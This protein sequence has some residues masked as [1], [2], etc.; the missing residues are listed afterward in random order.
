VREL[1]RRPNL[2]IKLSDLPVEADFESWTD[3][4]IRP[5]IE[6]T[7]DA[8]GPSRTIF[9][10][11]WPICLQATTMTGWVDL[12]DRAFADIGLSDTEKRAIYRNNAN[13]FYRLGL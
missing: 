4:D 2:W 1:A 11:D 7:L 12:L 10:G 9:A 5:Y 8:F 13:S 3:E 6:A